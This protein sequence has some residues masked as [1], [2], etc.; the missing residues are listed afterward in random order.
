MRLC[1]TFHRPYARSLV[2]FSGLIGINFGTWSSH[3]GELSTLARVSPSPLPKSMFCGFI[4]CFITI[5]N[6]SYNFVVFL[7]LFPCIC[8]SFKD[9]VSLSAF[10]GVLSIWLQIVLRCLLDSMLVFLLISFDS[11]FIRVLHATAALFRY[12]SCI[13]LV[14]TI[15]GAPFQTTLIGGQFSWSSTPRTKKA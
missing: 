8:C 7:P 12:Y 2:V 10:L 9:L 5:F 4:S 1:V 14:C 11:S 13:Y 3:A 6:Y 15:S